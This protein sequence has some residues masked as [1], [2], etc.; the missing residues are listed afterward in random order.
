MITYSIPLLLGFLAAWLYIWI[1]TKKPKHSNRWFSIGLV[2]AALVYLNLAVVAQAPTAALLTE[3][4]GVILFGVLAWI[5]SGRSSVLL[6]I[7]W[8]LHPVW[9]VALH[10]W[11]SGGDYAPEWYVWACISFDILVG[12]H[13]IRKEPYPAAQ[14]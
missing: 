7:G 11:A 1:A 8:F 2:V 4:G 6:T 14:G 9:D 13:L 12:V 3:S 5:A 10:V